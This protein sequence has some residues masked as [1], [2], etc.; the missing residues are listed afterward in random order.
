MCGI[1][2][3]TAPY[4]TCIL[5]L[6]LPVPLLIQCAASAPVKAMEDIQIHEPLPP[7]L[8]IWI[9]FQTPGLSLAQSWTSPTFGEREEDGRSLCV[10][11]FFSVTLSFKQSFLM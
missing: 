6:S 4:H 10:F 8:E 3:Q 9:E 5:C 2:N 1:A 7:A 11:P